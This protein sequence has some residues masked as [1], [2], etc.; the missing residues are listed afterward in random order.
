M[1]EKKLFGTTADG[2]QVNEFVIDNGT[3]E[4]HFLD[5]GCTIKNL[6]VTGKDGKKRDVVLGYDDIATSPDGDENFPGNL[7]V[8]VVYKLVGSSLDISYEATTD[9][10][11]PISLTNHS[12]F[13]LSDKAD[14]LDHMLRINADFITPVNESLI[15]TGEVLFVA[16]TPFDFRKFQKVF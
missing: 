16:D 6:F 15:P 10:D 8:K 4:A 3:I 9:A 7:S 13:N 14:V 11:T 12:Y 2:R 1:T 5:Y